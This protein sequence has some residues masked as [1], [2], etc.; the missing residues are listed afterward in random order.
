LCDAEH[1]EE[2]WQLQQ[3]TLLIAVKANCDGCRN[4]TDDEMEPLA[5]WPVLLVAHD[6][7]SAQEFRGSR[8]KVW[9]ASEL[10]DALD[11]KWPPFYLLIGPRPAR[12]LTEGVAFDAAQIAA[13][14][15]SAGV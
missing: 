10:L 8:N 5:Q 2:L 15:K 4:F 6:L 13:E 9:C 14:I 7:A 1:S 12:V 11:V 3:P